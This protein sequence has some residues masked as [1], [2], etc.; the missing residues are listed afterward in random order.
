MEQPVP[1]RDAHVPAPRHRRIGLVLLPSARR[2]VR[3]ELEG[4]GVCDLGRADGGHHT[5][6]VAVYEEDQWEAGDEAGGD[7]EPGEAREC[8]R[9]GGERG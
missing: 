7:Q 4:D 9:G 2:R 1:S 8:G 6:H 3:G 5:V